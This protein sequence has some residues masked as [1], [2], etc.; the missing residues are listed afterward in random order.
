MPIK[1]TKKKRRSNENIDVNN[2][3][4]NK[5]VT[6]TTKS[7]HNVTK[8]TSIAKLGSPVYTSPS[9]GPGTLILA[10]GS[11]LPVVQAPQVS[12]TV[13][14][15]PS[16]RKIACKGKGAKIP[17]PPLRQ[18]IPVK[19]IIKTRKKKI[20]EKILGNKIEPEKKMKVIEKEKTLKITENEKCTSNITT[21][22]NEIVKVTENEAG[23]GF[24]A[25]NNKKIKDKEENEKVLA[26]SQY[27]DKNVETKTQVNAENKN[28]HTEIY[29][30]SQKETQKFN[31]T[32]K[33]FTQSKVTENV[34]KI[35]TYSTTTAETKKLNN[36]VF[37]EQNTN[38]IFTQEKVTEKSLNTEIFTHNKNEIVYSTEQKKLTNEI[39]VES[40]N[41]QI[42]TPPKVVE[43][44][45]L[46]FTQN[47]NLYSQTKAEQKNLT[48]DIFTKTNNKQYPQDKIENKNL[49]SGEIFTQKIYTNQ[50][51]EPKKFP[52][53]KTFTQNNENIYTQN[54]NNGKN[55]N[56]D[57]FVQD[58]IY[59]RKPDDVNFNQNKIF[60]QNKNDT[61]K[62]NSDLFTKTNEN[63]L[64]PKNL[65]TEIYDNTNKNLFNQT[66]IV[67]NKL[68][69]DIFSQPK[70]NEKTLTTDI[71]ETKQ[72]YQPKT[73][74]NKLTTNI[75]TET[76][77]TQLYQPKTVENKL[78]TDIFTK[79]AEK[80]PNDI[81]AD[82]QTE[83]EPENAPQNDKLPHSEL[84]NDIFAELG[85]ASG[86][87]GSHHPESMSPT[88]AFLLAFP[89][90]S[91]LTSSASGG[92]VTN[93]LKEPDSRQDTPT[94]L[95][96]GTIETTNTTNSFTNSDY[97]WLQNFSQKK[98]D[99]RK[100]KDRKEFSAQYEVFKTQ[101]ENCNTFN[102]F[103]DVNQT[104][105]KN[106]QSTWTNYEYGKLLY[107][108]QKYRNL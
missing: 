13:I 10:N 7:T 37:V 93:T 95:Q 108:Y 11:V 97:G 39:L 12:T 21:T 75:F 107:C 65:V 18:K 68:T 43:N 14:L 85:G 50:K 32:N 45:K 83:R 53:S 102:P 59:T 73:A 98:N 56:S 35:T 1:T 2:K 76:N 89:L 55:L 4:Q 57:I 70:I 15:V 61:E 27:I 105:G 103:A 30:R 40:N 94:L 34:N 54:K 67:E 49:N 69:T 106:Y 79:E 29:T 62:L 90:V 96:I 5:K 36:E 19:N 84:S 77:K 101:S 8:A 31:F 52:Q 86:V 82:L 38:E 47:K 88:A 63:I 23:N 26:N 44:K 99:I 74:E 64:Q 42:Y 58:K 78:P 51:T 28:V 16:Q 87:P 91:T 60:T 100:S 6:K 92:Q 33:T 81:F 20:K 104:S 80:I 71:F 17:I 41:K 46:T 48:S 66:K 3:Q 22:E 9:L 24:T 72:L 25:N